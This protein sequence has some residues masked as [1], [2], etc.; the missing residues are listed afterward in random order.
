LQKNTVAT[1]RLHLKK[2]SSHSDALVL[3]NDRMA[4]TNCPFNLLYNTTPQRVCQ[5]N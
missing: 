4:Q 3:F 2:D 5:L 1:K